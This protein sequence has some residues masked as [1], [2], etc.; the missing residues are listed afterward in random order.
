MSESTFIC[1]PKNSIARVKFYHTTHLNQLE[2][3]KS[4]QK[5]NFFIEDA[6][7]VGGNKHHWRDIRVV[8]ELTKS[9]G[10]IVVK[11][12]QL[13]RYIREI[14]YAQPLRRFVRGFVVHKLHAEFLVVDRSGAYSSGE[15]SLIESEEKL[16]RAISS[17][18]FMSDEELGLDTTIFRKDGQSF[19]TIREGDEPV[20]NEIEIMPELIYRPET[21]VSQANLC[22]RTKDDMF[23]VKFSWGLGA[24]R[25]EID[26]LKLA[27]PVNGVVN[28][29]WGT[30]LNEV[31]TH[32]A[33]LDFSKAF[34]VSIKNNKWC[35]YKG[36]QNE[37]QTTPGYFRKR[38][39]TLAI[40]SPIG[41]PLKSSR[42]L[43]EFLN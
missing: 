43:R 17:Y 42:S 13:T 38:K 32:R 21:I 12:H 4:R 28:L 7:L 18:M 14:F 3:A 39:L 34:K 26:Y 9:A 37:P 30:V 20:D 36:L 5:L 2:G 1:T 22:H 40:L 19:I 41:R 8:G 23:T 27:K 33:G 25:S 35:L 24:E 29:V 15:I 31:E 16:V 6:D 11:F 10:L